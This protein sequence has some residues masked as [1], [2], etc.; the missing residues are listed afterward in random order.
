MSHQTP[1]RILLSLTIACAIS[2]LSTSVASEEASA[3][4]SAPAPG[5]YD[6][7]AITFDTSGKTLRVGYRDGKI[8]TIDL[9]KKRGTLRTADRDKNPIVAV[10]PNG[11]SAVI[12]A[13]PVAII[14]TKRGK[15]LAEISKFKHLEDAVYSRDGELLLISGPDKLL[16]W[17][18][19][20]DLD[21][22]AKKGIRLEEYLARQD[23]D[24][25]VTIGE[26]HAR[27]D[28]SD[29]AEHPSLLFGDREGLLTLWNMGNRS[30]ANFIAK[31]PLPHTIR[32]IHREIALVASAS[33]SLLH[34]FYHK[35]GKR[36]SWN[37][38]LHVHAALS[39]S[40]GIL[41][42]HDDAIAL[43]D[44]EDGH[45]LWRQQADEDTTFS[46]ESLCG[47]VKWSSEKTHRLALCH[48]QTIHIYDTESGELLASFQR[49]K[50]KI[51][52]LKI[53]KKKK[54]S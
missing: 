41:L 28:L 46:S 12:D 7:S 53:K 33:D 30:E 20:D 54:A 10:A 49:Q 42:V 44:P 36:L 40:P 27:M 6:V 43:H 34:V 52:A 22:L 8:A 3:K 16:I 35:D 47:L 29:D 18:D 23:G 26:M 38:T 17:K 48:E 32:T 39:T 37:K 4:Q 5:K 31:L 19:A 45:V 14:E 1:R 15:H 13:S 9:G 51:S 50:S 24:Q 11:R 21:S 2:L 25:L